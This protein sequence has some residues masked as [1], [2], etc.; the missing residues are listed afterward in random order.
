MKHPGIKRKKS[1]LYN[2]PLVLRN[3][4]SNRMLK[5]DIMKLFALIVSLHKA[6]E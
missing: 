6:K 5:R 4:R 1:I 2:I 3:I